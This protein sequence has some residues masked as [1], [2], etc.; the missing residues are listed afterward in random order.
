MSHVPRDVVR[1]RKKKTFIC[2]LG[3]R[4]N[5]GFGVGLSILM[6]SAVLNGRLLADWRRATEDFTSWTAIASNDNRL[7][8]NRI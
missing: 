8:L 3:L 4:L 6:V 7:A 1:R 5:F 2:A